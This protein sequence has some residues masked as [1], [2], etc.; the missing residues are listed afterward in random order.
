VCKRNLGVKI[1]V[2]L[3]LLN[4]LWL[5]VGTLSARSKW[6]WTLKHYDQMTTAQR[7]DS[8]LLAGRLA[9]RAG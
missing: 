9:T 4:I 6:R 8:V 2:A 3:L 5:W 7:L 1:A